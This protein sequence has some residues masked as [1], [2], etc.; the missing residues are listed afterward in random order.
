MYS[1]GQVPF[2]S[3]VV[4]KKDGLCT[5]LCVYTHMHVCVCVCACVCVRDK[6]Q[7]QLSKSSQSHLIH[8]LDN[9]SF[10]GG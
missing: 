8:V 4:E 1:E 2:F 9:L 3:R 5:P 10:W 6:R 7:R